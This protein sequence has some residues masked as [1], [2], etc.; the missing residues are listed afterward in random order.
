M[1]EEVVDHVSDVGKSWIRKLST[2]TVLKH[3]ERWAARGPQKHFLFSFFLL[4]CCDFDLLKHKC[5]CLNWPLSN[6]PTD[7]S[8]TA[9][10]SVVGSLGL[11]QG[12]WRHYLKKSWRTHL[13]S[14]STH[15]QASLR[16]V[17]KCTVVLHQ[18]YSVQLKCKVL[19]QMS[20]I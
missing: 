9:L 4:K 18:V 6:R 20:N 13:Q 2:F 14:C 11:K 17:I 16:T 8:L 3:S 1:Q 15:S 10:Q 19:S 7:H 5:Y 12:T